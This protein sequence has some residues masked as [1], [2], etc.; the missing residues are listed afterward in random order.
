MA[1]DRAWLPLSPRTSIMTGQADDDAAAS[2]LRGHA[3]S[4]GFCAVNGDCR[5]V[6]RAR[7]GSAA[8]ACDAMCVE[9]TGWRTTARSAND[10]AMN[11]NTPRVPSTPRTRMLC[12][13]VLAACAPSQPEVRSTSAASGTTGIDVAGIDRSV[14]PGDDF[15]G[16]ANGGWLKSHD[17]PP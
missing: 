14:S 17:I 10:R 3:A 15:F 1:G 2:R 5:K 11:S 13:A 6:N 16:Y 7:C 8:T 12:L 9:H 4:C